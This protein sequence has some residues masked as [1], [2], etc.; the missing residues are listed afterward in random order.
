MI[1][2]FVCDDMVYDYESEH[3]VIQVMSGQQHAK[4]ILG[5]TFY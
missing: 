3:P 2:L 5:R 1:S 4:A